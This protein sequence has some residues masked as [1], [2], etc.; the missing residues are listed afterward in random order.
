MW[1]AVALLVFSVAYAVLRAA[2]GRP[3]RD[4]PTAPAPSHGLA[5]CL[6]L[7]MGFCTFLVRIV[8]PQ[9]TNILNMQLCYFSQYILLFIVGVCAWR[10]NWLLRIP[11]GFGLR[12]LG[13]ALGAGGLAWAG[14]VVA[15]IR[16]HSTEKLAGGF[17]WQS[18]ALCFWESL[19]C[20]GLCLGVLVVFRENLNRHSK[21]TRWLSDNCFAV[22]LFHTPILIAITL[23]L[24]GWNAPKLMKFS[25]ATVLAVVA[26]YLA[27]SLLFRRIPGLKRIL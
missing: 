21:F 5:L 16:T 9:G 6:I 22:Y 3:P 11:L 23:S 14:I 15:A 12:W 10:R 18:A 1:F 8:Q 24:R 7:V 27:S 4:C 20:V 19:V 2:I 13:L 17:T 26:T 25:G